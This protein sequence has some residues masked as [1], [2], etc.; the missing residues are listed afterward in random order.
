[1]EQKALPRALASRF[2]AGEKTLRKLLKSYQAPL[3]RLDRTLVG[4]LDS[5]ERKMLH[6][7][8]KLK[9]KAGRAE[10]LRIGVLDRYER[11]L[12]DS[13]Y[14]HRALQERSVSPLPW[15]AEYGPTFLDG[16]AR[17]AKVEAQQHHIVYL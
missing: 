13:L 3:R 4:A 5:A 14:P 12:L 6:Q 9:G 7:F 15:L 16:L 2:D 10:N 11:I 8:A 1:M 17:L